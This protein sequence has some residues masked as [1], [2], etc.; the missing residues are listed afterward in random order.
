MKMSKEQKR[1][2]GEM[3]QHK[4]MEQWFDNLRVAI[5]ESKLPWQQP[6]VGGSKSMPHNLVSGKPYRGGNIMQLWITAVSMGWTDLRFA[7]RKQLLKKG[8]SIEGL[9]N[10]EGIQIQFYKPQKYTVE[11]DDGEKE[12]RRG[13][14]TRWYT[15]FCV[16]QC[17]DYVAPEV[18]E[19]EAVPE[20]DMM[21]HFRDYVDS[22][23][24]LVLE[25]KGERAYYNSRDDVIGLP[26]HEIFKDSL[27][28]VMTAFHEAVHS[29]G[30]K[31]RL[32][33]PL[34]NKFG[35]SEYAYEELIAEMGQLLITLTLG[36]EF[37][38][39]LVNEEHANNHAYLKCW[40]K[41]CDDRDKMLSQAFSGA[42]KAADYIMD[43]LMD[44]DEE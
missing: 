38:P 39:A 2:Y 37:Q 21:A 22:Q 12:T 27:G 34:A 24:Y 30:H 33:R 36:G 11:N 44:G 8:Q 26:P 18:E 13:W 14:V 17:N 19:V 20:S 29:T 42:Q 16:E 5:L 40:L 10:D 31:D 35:S 15:V 9:T 25:R 28:E 23:E 4:N 41:A 43:V 7:T 1:A 6:W 32:A 3:I